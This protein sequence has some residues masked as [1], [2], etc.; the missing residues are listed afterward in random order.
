[1]NVRIDASHRTRTINDHATRR[2]AIQNVVRNGPDM[3]D[4]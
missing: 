1:M 2:E 3:M 4:R